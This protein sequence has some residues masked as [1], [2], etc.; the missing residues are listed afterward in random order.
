MTGRS[1][2]E[3]PCEAIDTEAHSETLDTDG[4][5]VAGEM[6]ALQETG[7]ERRTVPAMRTRRRGGAAE[8]A[9][10]DET[11]EAGMKEL[12]HLRPLIRWFLVTD[13]MER[14]ETLRAV[15]G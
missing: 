2:Y 3:D 4:P 13:D 7:A 12:L 14:L 11:M 1:G 10:T 8:Q 9:G 6:P 5:V 15:Y